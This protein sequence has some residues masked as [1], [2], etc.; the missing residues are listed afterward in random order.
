M[1]IKQKALVT[2]TKFPHSVGKI[3]SNSLEYTRADYEFM[4]VAVLLYI[5]YM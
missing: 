3:N 1:K 5:S 4:C 2:M